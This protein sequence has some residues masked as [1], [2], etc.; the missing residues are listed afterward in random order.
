MTDGEGLH[1]LDRKVRDR[2][3]DELGNAAGQLEL[4]RLRVDLDQG[5]HELAAVRPVDHPGSPA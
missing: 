4:L 1:L 3:G 5:D 2:P